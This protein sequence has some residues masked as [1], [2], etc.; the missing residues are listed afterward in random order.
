LV[1]VTATSLVAEAT[2]LLRLEPVGPQPLAPFS[3]GAHIDVHLGDGMTRQYSLIGAPGASDSY[4]ICVRRD[5]RGRGGSIVIHDD[6]SSGARLQISPPRNTFSLIPDTTA[7][8]LGGGIGLTPL[9]SMAET[10]HA[11]DAEFELHV[12]ARSAAALPLREHL[13]ERPWAD[14][15][16]THFSEQGDSFRAAAPAALS[17]P[18]RRRM[19][20]VCG[21]EGFVELARRRASTSGWGN[22]QVRSEQF[23]VGNVVRDADS[24]FDVVATSTG[25]RMTISSHE[26]IADVLE[27]HG[28]ETYRS[29]GQGYCGSCV[30]AVR[31][32]NPDHRDASQT[33]QEHISGGLINVCVSR[34]L[35][36]V[37]ELEV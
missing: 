25:E 21:P 3:A 13:L 37:L 7:L 12:Y 9:V 26:S 32:G 11:N 2:M 35:S 34:S 4:L 8:L 14:R 36:P 22:D 29:C 6:V 30:M 23:T 16:H 19:I 10:L 18:D 33:A 24:S 5:S 17:A 31:S 20:Y 1:R 15:L 27:R 28:Y